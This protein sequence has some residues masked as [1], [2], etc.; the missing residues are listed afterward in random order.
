[1]QVIHTHFWMKRQEIVAQIEG[2]ILDMETQS[3]DRRTGRAISLNAMALKVWFITCLFS[4]CCNLDQVAIVG[5]TFS[6][7]G[8]VSHK[9]S[10]RLHYRKPYI[11]KDQCLVYVLICWNLFIYVCV[12]CSNSD[13]SHTAVF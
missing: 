9:D 6:K 5:G 7:Q 3:G 13:S 10:V 1:M 2:W 11:L 4:H 12:S 8:S